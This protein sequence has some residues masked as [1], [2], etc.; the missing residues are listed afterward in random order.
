MKNWAQNFEYSAAN[1][2]MPRTIEEAQEAIAGSDRVKALGTRHSFTDIADSPDGL[3]ISL[4]QMDT[5]I[6]IDGETV[7]IN[8][9]TTY[10]ELVAELEA[11]GRA[12]P[13]LGSLPHI[14]VGGA[15]ATAT[16]GSG[17]SN[18]VLSAHISAIELIKSDGSMARVDRANADFP[19]LVVGLGAFGLFTR[20]ELTTQPSF[21]VQQHMYR[22]AS[23]ERVI[24]SL[25][26]ALAF[27]Y[28][29]CL[30][31]N[32]GAPQMSDI[33]VKHRI[34]D[35][36]RDFPVD[37]YGGARIGE[38]ALRPG[39]SLTQIE[40]VVG[41]WS[42]RLP[43]FRPDG[44][45]SVG[46]DELQTEYFVDRRHGAA[47][48]RAL[49][50]MGDQIRPHLHGMEIRSLAPDDFWLSPAYER[51]SLCLGF[52]WRKHPEEVL[53]LL[54]KIE[55]ALVDFEPRAHWGKLFSLPDVAGR[56]P[57][58]GDFVALRD[59]YDPGRKFWNPFLDRLTAD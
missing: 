35:T 50:A 42:E 32:I 39:H 27:A 20:L 15:T 18:Q 6:E 4:E 51:P 29:V 45:P 55:E 38:D 5:S 11:N 53:S 49:R 34:N 46:G 13:N 30:L 8:P 25:D 24:D 58:T 26:D 2:V 23:W 33:W 40:G 1:V 59:S 10:S 3:L 36:P 54:P 41:P 56:Y 22:G 44:E 19:A 47:A 14:S 37:F 21:E 28:S 17:D 31:G 57:R 52:T 7:S 43:H 16:H 9:A 48:L 12:L